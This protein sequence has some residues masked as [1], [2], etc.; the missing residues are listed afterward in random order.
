M[1]TKKRES[2]KIY[3]S[4]S[5]CHTSEGLLRRD[6][7]I[8]LTRVYISIRVKIRVTIAVRSELMQLRKRLVL[9]L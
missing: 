3:H 1:N 8:G 6:L 4:R 5:D 7:V 9:G 2:E